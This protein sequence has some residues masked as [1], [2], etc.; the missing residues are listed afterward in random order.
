MR[1]HAAVLIPA[2]RRVRVR[3]RHGRHGQLAVN[4]GMHAPLEFL[5]V[6]SSDGPFS[7]AYCVVCKGHYEACTEIRMLA[8]AAAFPAQAATRAAGFSQVI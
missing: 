4:V 1:R 6:H 8:A 2:F 7:L 5:A 3:R